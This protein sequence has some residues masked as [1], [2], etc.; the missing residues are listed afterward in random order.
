LT[1]PAIFWPGSGS[2]P[3]GRTSLGL[4]DDDDAFVEDAPKVA[5]WVCQRLGYPVMDIEMTDSQLYDCFEEAITEYSSQV[6]EF[7]LRENLFALQGIQTSG[8]NFTHKLVAPNPLPFIIEISKAYGTEA[9]TGGKVDWKKGYVDMVA[10]QQEYD[11]QALWAAVSESGNRI[12]IRRVFHE[13]TPAISRGGFGFGDVGGGP[14]DGQNYLLG[15]FG[16]AGYDGGL[17]AAGG[18][19]TG[20]FLMMPIF[21][22]VLRT[23]AIEFNDTIRRSQFSFELVNNKMRVMPIP[24]WNDRIWF[25]YLVEKDRYGSP[26][27]GSQPTNSVVSD[28]S[29]APYRDML[30]T[31]I[32]DVGRRW[33][34][35]YTLALAKE[36]LGRILSKYESLP[37]PNSEVRM[38][39]PTLRQEAEKEKDILWEQLRE[40][41]GETG[42]KAQMEKLR[43]NEE[44]SQEILKKA[45]LYIYIG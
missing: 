43:E 31:N 10:G 6:N 44:N 38:D 1:I 12:E 17:N 32:N 40:T 28:Y 23:Q 9:G 36:T 3:V 42:R 16:W 39:G 35:R 33:I 30:Y 25:H 27:S 5:A 45:P 22:T 26:I 13:R 15:E 4:Y 37:I 41:L 20:Q 8:S 14:N 34:R 11:L 19:T 21:E 2:N 18:A 29:N 24:T 7:N